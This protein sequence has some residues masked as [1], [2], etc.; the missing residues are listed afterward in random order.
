MLIT[1]LQIKQE[2]ALQYDILKALTKI[3]DPRSLAPFLKIL[4]T[5]HFPK[6][7]VYF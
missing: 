5:I 6:K 3:K 2:K 4:H 1:L 7:L